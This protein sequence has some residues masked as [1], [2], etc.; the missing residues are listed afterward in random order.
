[1]TRTADPTR[2]LFPR[3]I[4]T[5]WLL[6]RRLTAALQQAIAGSVQPGTRLLDFGCGTM[7]YRAMVEACGARYTGA[8]FGTEAE[9]AITPDGRIAQPDG[10]VDAVLSV[11]VLEHVRDLDRYFAEAARVLAPDGRLI[12]STHGTWLYHPHPEDHRRWTRTGLIHDIETRGFTVTGIVPLVG[13]LGWTTMLRLTGFAYA[14]RPIPV[15]GPVLTA[16]LAIVMNLRAAFEDAITPAAITADN[17]CVYVVT[18]RKSGG[19]AA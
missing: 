5:D 8:D 15:A 17:A 11:Q 18:A 2:R 3:L 16:L 10:S 4:D 1:M 19:A 9:V 7:P 13:P 14:L 12:L 6:L